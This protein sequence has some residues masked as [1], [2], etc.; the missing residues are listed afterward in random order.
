[1]QGS[2]KRPAWVT[3][4][5][6]PYP[7]LEG[8]SVN[9]GKRM[10]ELYI[11]APIRNAEVLTVQ[12]LRICIIFIS[13]SGSFVRLSQPDPDEQEGDRRDDQPDYTRVPPTPFRGLA[14]PEQKQH[15]PGRQQEGPAPVDPAG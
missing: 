12:I 13:T 14:H 4:A 9:S 11:P 2:R 1:M 7:A 6:N 5:P 3:E 8:V 10:N 15:H